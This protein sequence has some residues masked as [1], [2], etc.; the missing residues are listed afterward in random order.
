[1]VTRII[2]KLIGYAGVKGDDRIIDTCDEGVI[3]AISLF[4]SEEIGIEI[5][6]AFTA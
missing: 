2:Y 5:I 3:R 4:L 6:Q 1:M